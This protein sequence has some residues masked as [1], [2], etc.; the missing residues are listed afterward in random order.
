M[1]FN[2]LTCKLQDQ[3]VQQELLGSGRYGEVWRIGY[4]DKTYAGKIIH[5]N[6][7]PGYPDI[8]VDQIK[9][10][11]ADIENIYAIFG[12]HEHP[13]IEQYYTITQPTPDDPPILLS[14]LLPDNLN[15]FTA[16]MKGKLPIHV[17]LDLCLDMAKGVQYLHANGV[18]HNNLHAGNVL[19]SQVGKAKISDYIC[20][21]NSELNE[22]TTLQHKDYMS[23]ELIKNH[24]I[25]SRPSDI[26][27]LGVLFLQV[28]T[29]STPTPTDSKN[30]ELS[31]VQRHKHQLDEIT[32]NPLLPV[33][34]QCLNILPARPSIDHLCDR[35]NTAKQ[36][37]QNVMSDTINHVKVRSCYV[38]GKANLCL[39]STNLG[40]ACRSEVIFLNVLLKK[41]F[42]ITTT[43]GYQLY[44]VR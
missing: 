8:G 26:Y 33:I 5:K 35:I 44:K 25:C 23:P 24:A 20:P 12:S 3:L 39:S 13:N 32:T 7:L 41:L 2:V 27:S 18:I 10:F 40:S 14:Q 19:I 4:G 28:A 36:S 22:K 21:Q 1:M 17:Q 38:L 43:A 37:P 11:V 9:Q 31:E 29:K 6:L 16:K 30:S 34:M 15:S 42:K